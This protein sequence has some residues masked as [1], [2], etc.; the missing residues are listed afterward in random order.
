M[1]WTYQTRPRMM[2]RRPQSSAEMMTGARSCP[3]SQQGPARSGTGAWGMGLQLTTLQA[4]PLNPS[5][6]NL[7]STKKTVLPAA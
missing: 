6:F 5:A 2:K 1:M 7:S 3:T 4:G